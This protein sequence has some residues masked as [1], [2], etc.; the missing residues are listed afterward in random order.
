[1]MKI[2]PNGQRVRFC[3]LM[4]YHGRRVCLAKRPKCPECTIRDLC[5]FPL[6]TKG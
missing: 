6:K 2:V 4:Q 5:P 3:H 1:L